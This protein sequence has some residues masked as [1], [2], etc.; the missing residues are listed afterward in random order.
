MP[1]DSIRICSWVCLIC[2]SIDNPEAAVGVTVGAG[3][4]LGA[5]D[6]GATDFG[7]A[8]LVTAGTATASATG[9][10]SVFDDVFVSFLTDAFGFDVANV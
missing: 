10:A 4:A 5:A 1:E 6:L 2:S 7:A 8:G 9:K 3:T